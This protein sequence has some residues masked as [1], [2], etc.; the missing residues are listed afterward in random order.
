VATVHAQYGALLRLRLSGGRDE[1]REN[2]NGGRKESPHERV[3]RR[4]VPSL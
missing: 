4:V 2:G 1:Q 3:C